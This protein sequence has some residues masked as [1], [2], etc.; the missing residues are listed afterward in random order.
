V[1][2]SAQNPFG[3]T[4]LHLLEKRQGAS[5][6]IPSG[7]AAPQD[8]AIGQLG[9]DA[10][11][12]IERGQRVLRDQGNLGTEEPA[13][14]MPSEGQEVAPAERNRSLREA[15]TLRQDAENRFGNR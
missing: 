9:L 11:A 12:R 13:P 6:G 3:L 7:Q 4:H 2:K 15:D 14:L 10:P 5:P 1:G 8:K